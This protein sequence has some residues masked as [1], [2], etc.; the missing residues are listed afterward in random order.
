M[1]P[2]LRPGAAQALRGGLLPANFVMALLL[3]S[4]R[5]SWLR[6]GP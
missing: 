3:F 5:E 6:G 4:A 1:D 2:D